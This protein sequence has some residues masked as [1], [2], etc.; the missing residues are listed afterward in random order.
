MLAM[1]PIDGC[2]DARRLGPVDILTRRDEIRQHLQICESPRVGRGW[3]VAA[4]ALIIVS[5]GIEFLRLAQ[6]R[7]GQTRMLRRSISRKSGQYRSSFQRE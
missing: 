7:F 1:N 3:R 4:D 2:V 5:L 6:P